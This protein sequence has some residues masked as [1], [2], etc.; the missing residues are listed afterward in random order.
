MAKEAARDSSRNTLVMTP[1]LQAAKDLRIQSRD[2]TTQQ[3]IVGD[4]Q[5][6]LASATADWQNK[7]NQGYITQE[8]MNSN[9]AAM[10][11]EQAAVLR[12]QG[13]GGITEPA[14]T[15]TGFQPPISRG[16]PAQ[17]QMLSVLQEGMAKGQ[18][19]PEVQISMIRNILISLEQNPPPAQAGGAVDMQAAVAALKADQ[20]SRA[21]V[22]LPPLMSGGGYGP[23]VFQ[24]L[25][26]QSGNQPNSLAQ[27][28]NSAGQIQ[29]DKG[30]INNALPQQQP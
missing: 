28:P 11:A 17:Q 26:Q 24:A 29:P 13:L 8:Q 19:R 21:A 23:E 14:K 9:V 25:A 30:I 18:L 4:Q 2:Y 10:K 12:G 16:S 6:L 22:G 3:R 27:L 7:V 20:E 5:Q 15:P 1:A